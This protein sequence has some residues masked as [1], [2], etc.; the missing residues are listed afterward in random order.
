MGR[1]GRSRE[2]S[3]S[4]PRVSDAW[5]GASARGNCRLEALAAR[6]ARR[7]P[8]RSPYRV[9]LRE[10]MARRAPRGALPAL[11]GATHQ[12][13]VESAR[14]PVVLDACVRAGADEVADGR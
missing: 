6:E 14:V 11:A 1:M 8:A 12:R 7:H 4:G 10:Q 5:S 2:R 13:D 3:C 9:D